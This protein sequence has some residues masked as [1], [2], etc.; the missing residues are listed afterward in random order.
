MEGATIP[1]SEPQTH[2]LI[3]R[4]QRNEPGAYEEF[5]AQ[6]GPGLLRF[7]R[8]MCG[9]PDDAQEVLQD[10]L[11]KTFQ[12]IG[13]LKNPGAF[14]SWLYR[15]LANACLMRRRKSQFL[16]EEVPLEETLPERES[17]DAGRPWAQLPDRVLQNSELHRILEKALLALPPNYRLV[18]LLRDVEGLSTE[19]TAK[20]LGVN[21]DVAKMRLHRA[22]AMMRNALD[23]YLGN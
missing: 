15:I 18:I 6:F 11:L 19:E 17:L 4:L 12:S 23:S 2:E 3:A 7:G 10:T 16:E 13:T 1:V 21:K 9:D 8:R 14:K 5:M 22:R 20:A